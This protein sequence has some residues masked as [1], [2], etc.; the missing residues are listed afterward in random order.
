MQPAGQLGRLRHQC[1][2][3]VI[4]G[5]IT[6]ECLFLF[7]SFSV[8]NCMHVRIAYVFICRFFR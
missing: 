4:V 8:V 2:I 3:V 7:F 5:V 6:P 1:Q